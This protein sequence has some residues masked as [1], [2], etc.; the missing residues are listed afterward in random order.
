MRLTFRLKLLSIGGVAAFAFV[1]LIVAGTL[2]ARRVE[3]DLATIQG[4]YLPRLELEPQLETHFERL[5]R[6]FQDAVA[7]RDIDALTATRDERESFLEVLEG[8]RS[9]VDPE[10]AARLRRA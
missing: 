3:T 7:A 8:A 9:A 4:R 5:Q 2:I 6:G 1:L 10:Q